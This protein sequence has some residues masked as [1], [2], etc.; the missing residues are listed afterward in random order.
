MW[1]NTFNTQTI[2]VSAL[3]TKYYEV[4]C[5]NE[6][7]TTASIDLLVTVCPVFQ[8]FTSPVDDFS[9]TP[10]NQPKT[11]QVINA[12]NL[13]YSTVQI[14]KTKVNYKASMSINLEPGFK[15]ENGAIF[16]AEIAVC[17]ILVT[18]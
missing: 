18:P 1:E 10:A 13:I 9:I 2:S 8:N 3:R 7:C 12:C 11:S 4:K 16:K 17:E 15:V 6:V 14:P 5:T